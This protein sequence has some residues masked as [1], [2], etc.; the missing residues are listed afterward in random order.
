MLCTR[1]CLRSSC[2]PSSSRP[3]LESVAR[4]SLAAQRSA[5]RRGSRPTVLVSAAGAPAKG[6]GTESGRK[7]SGA[8]LWQ[9]ACGRAA[10]RAS[11]SSGVWGVC[12]ER[13]D[14]A[15][16]C[17]LGL[18]RPARQLSVA[19]TRRPGWRTEPCCCYSRTERK[20]SQQ[21]SKNSSGCFSRPRVPVW[22]PL[23]SPPP[24]ATAEVLPSQGSLCRPLRRPPP[25][26]CRPA[27]PRRRAL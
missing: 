16:T 5:R 6:L 2:R 27:V 26:P 24:R 22:P 10:G 1:T 4:Q 25:P 23:F 19:L 20:Q 18:A 3:C 11:G 12:C 9:R 7:A 8:R 15:G 21:E 13:P 17:V 14:L